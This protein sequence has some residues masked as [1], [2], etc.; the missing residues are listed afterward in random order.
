MRLDSSDRSSPHEVWKKIWKAK[1][2]RKFQIFIWRALH[3]IVPCLY[4]LA[5]HHIGL[6]INCPVCTIDAEDLHHMIFCCP[7][8]MEIWVG[9]GLGVL[10]RAARRM[11]RSGSLVLEELVCSPSPGGITCNIHNF[12]KLVMITC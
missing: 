8:S 12:S 11:D 1:V 2:S 10:I 3:G 7:Q 5:N 6:S 4:A 9:L